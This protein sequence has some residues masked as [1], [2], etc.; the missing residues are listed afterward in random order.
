[1]PLFE[2]NLL[3]Y[4]YIDKE[5]LFWWKDNFEIYKSQDDFKFSQESLFRNVIIG[6]NRYS[7][8]GE[9]FHKFIEFDQ[10]TPRPDLKIITMHDSIKM[11]R[12]RFQLINFILYPNNNIDINFL[13]K[14]YS[15]ITDGNT[16]DINDSILL[17]QLEDNGPRYHEIALYL[18]K[19]VIE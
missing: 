2:A 5:E 9:D 19:W 16:L 3:K 15:F 10:V 18:E 13:G 17:Y 6:H 1:M 11:M 7:H 8:S 12:I 14:E 4:R